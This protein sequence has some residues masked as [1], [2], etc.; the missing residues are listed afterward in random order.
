MMKVEGAEHI[1]AVLE[2]MAQNQ[3]RNLLRSTVQGV[4]MQIARDARKAA[5]KDSGV[6]RKAIKARRRRSHP[7]SPRSDVYIEHGRGKRNDAWYWHF[8]EFGT[9]GAKPQPARPYI[10]P[11][12]QRAEAEMPQRMRDEF[13]LKYRRMLEREAKRNARA[14]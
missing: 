5:P 9:G 14:V 8:S 12:L 13:W 1:R 3:A 11:A 4:A 10:R 6:L 2:G 7:D